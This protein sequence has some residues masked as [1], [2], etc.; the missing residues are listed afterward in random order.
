MQLHKERSLRYNIKKSQKWANRLRIE[1]NTNKI[2]QKLGELVAQ[3]FDRISLPGGTSIDGSFY[4]GAI[5]VSYD[6]KTK[7]FYF[8]GV[9]YNSRFYL[10]GESRH[11]KKSGETPEEAV[12][13]EVLE[14]TGVQIIS[15]NLTLA[16]TK[17]IPDNRPGKIGQNHCKYFYLVTEFTGTLFTFDG[18]NPIDGETAAPIWIPAELFLKKIFRGHLDAVQISIGKLMEMNREYAYAL[19]NVY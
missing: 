19:M 7:E 10:K 13:R 18:P 16:H 6:S 14:E 3:G 15:K 5:V 8:L 17:S 2:N 9:P 1:K 12:I 4:A 11:N